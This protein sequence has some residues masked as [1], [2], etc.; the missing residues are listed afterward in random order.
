VFAVW[1]PILA[2]DW[3]RPGTSVLARLKDRR[4]AQFWDP[5]HLLARKLSDEARDPQPKPACC[6]RNGILWDLAA[7][8]PPGA[9]W[10]NSVP[11]AIFFNGAVTKVGDE[12][13]AKLVSIQ[14]SPAP[15]AR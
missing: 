8:Y 4:A 12:L 15:A 11:P 14:K 2:T 3:S 10:S 9:T 13:Q 5:D 6:R 7:V 1:E